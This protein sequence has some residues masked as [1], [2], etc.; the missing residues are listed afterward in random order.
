MLPGLVEWLRLR[1]PDN[2]CEALSSNPSAERKKLP[3]LVLY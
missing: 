1:V 2:R 3:K